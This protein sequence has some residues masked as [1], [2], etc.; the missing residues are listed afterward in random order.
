MKKIKKEAFNASDKIFAQ[1]GDL[2]FLDDLR[3]WKL[4]NKAIT[5]NSFLPKLI[6][7]ISMQTKGELKNLT[8]TTGFRTV[9]GMES[10]ESLYKKELEQR[11]RRIYEGA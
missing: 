1:V 10:L 3:I 7:A 4:G 8:R 5:D 2:S 9:A 6:E 11:S